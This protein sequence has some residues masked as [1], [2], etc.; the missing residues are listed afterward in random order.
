MT[1][2][3]LLFICLWIY[4]WINS[5]NILSVPTF[6][7][8]AARMK[9]LRSWETIP[10]F[11]PPCLSLLLSFS[12]DAQLGRHS[13]FMD[14]ISLNAQYIDIS[15]NKNFKLNINKCITYLVIQVDANIPQRRTTRNAV[16]Q[17]LFSGS[18]TVYCSLFY[19]VFDSNL[20]TFTASVKVRKKRKFCTEVDGILADW[21]TWAAYGESVNVGTFPKNTWN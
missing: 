5:D 8:S 14:R 12:L 1:D 21:I 9:L 20:S 13:L 7:T 16:E 6:L 19:V 10:V 17:D 3:K 15:Y 18:T 2:V 11:K 4:R